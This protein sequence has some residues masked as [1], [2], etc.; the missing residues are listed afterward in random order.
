MFTQRGAELREL[1]DRGCSV[2]V[3]EL[4]AHDLAVGALVRGVF[5]DQSTP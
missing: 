5:P 1:A 3:V 2:A 4:A